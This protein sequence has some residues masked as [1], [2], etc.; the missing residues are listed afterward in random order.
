[1]APQFDDQQGT[2]ADLSAADSIDRE[3]QTTKER[4]IE[5]N[6]VV[7][8]CNGRLQ[9]FEQRHP[10]G[11]APLE[12]RVAACAD[13]QGKLRRA[14]AAAE[15]ASSTIERVKDDVHGNFV[16]IL[17]AAVSRAVSTFSAGR[18]TQAFVDPEDFS[19]RVRLPETGMHAP[20]A[21]LSSGTREQLFLALRAATAAA[22]GSG[23]RVPLLLDDALVHSDDD[24]LRAAVCHLAEL[25]QSG[26]QIVLFTQREA[27]VRA[28]RAQP[29]VSVI[30]LAGPA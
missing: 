9:R 21:E 24:H 5:L 6:L 7:E 10:Q 30:A 11:A 4:L 28:A 14:K 22:L 13:R 25:A 20:S 1:M 19:V 3:I 26:Q 2:G 27:V 18:Y 8:R 29:K 15:L 12:E 17:S 23:E 16:P